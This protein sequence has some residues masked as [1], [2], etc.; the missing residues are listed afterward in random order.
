MYVIA[1]NNPI[2]GIDSVGLTSIGTSCSTGKCGLDASAYAA[3]IMANIIKT[4]NGWGF[5]KQC[6]ACEAMYFPPTAWND[7]DM[8]TFYGTGYPGPG[9]PACSHTFSYAGQCYWGG[10]LN[11]LQWGLMNRLCGDSLDD[12]LVF[13]LSFKVLANHNDPTGPIV[14]QALL[15]TT[16]GY[17]GATPTGGGLGCS[18][19]SSK[20]PRDDTGWRWWPYKTLGVPI[21]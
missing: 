13:A 11:Y 6:V 7:W 12:A 9:E 3:G 2:N 21:F 4:F 16:I 15:M 14:F 8:Q 10:S 17:T 18:Y 5:A 1:L 20:L 19:I